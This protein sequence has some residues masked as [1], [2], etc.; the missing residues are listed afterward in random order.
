MAEIDT[1]KILELRGV[2]AI[3]IMDFNREFASILRALNYSVDKRN[4]FYRRM[5]NIFSSSCRELDSII[6]EIEFDKKHEII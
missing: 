3:A 6:D 5:N 1:S 2:L 4:Y